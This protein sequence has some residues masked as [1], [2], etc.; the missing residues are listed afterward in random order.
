[1]DDS[2]PSIFIVGKPL[3]EHHIQDMALECELYTDP[4]KLIHALKV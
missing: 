2:L 4:E 3:S 1:M